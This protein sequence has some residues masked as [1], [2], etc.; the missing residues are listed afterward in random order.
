MSD[1]GPHT[2]DYCG[3]SS[4]VA[5]GALDFALGYAEERTQFGKPIARLPRAAVH[6][7]RHGHEGGGSAPKLTYAA[8]WRVRTRRPKT[9]RSL[10][11][12]RNACASDVAME[13]TTNAVVVLGGYGY[14]RD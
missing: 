4:G 6:A 7:R 8:G 14:T 11:L 9:S 12:P 5:R 1:A 13:V 10:V 2:G 3:P